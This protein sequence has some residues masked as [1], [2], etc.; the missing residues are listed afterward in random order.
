MKSLLCFLTIGIVAFSA[1]AEPRFWGVASGDMGEN[2]AVLWTRV[3]DQAAPAQLA[4][5]VTV[6]TE[7]S[8]QAA[9]IVLEARTSTAR[10]Y[11]AKVS[12]SGPKPG[13]L[14]YYQ[15][16]AGSLKS[17]VGRFKTG[18]E[19]EALVP[20]TFGFSGDAEGLMR[21]CPLT[22]EFPKLGLDFFA[23]LGEVIYETGSQGSTAG[24]VSGTV[25]TPS[26]K[27]ATRARLFGDYS[28]KYREQPAAV[29][30]GGQKGAA[31]PFRVAGQLHAGQPLFP[32]WVFRGM[33]QT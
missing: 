27:G 3:V 1:S 14:S 17:T 33:V 15:F 32:T 26:D 19:A 11:T 4:L 28:R 8:L 29:N 31:G 16:V 12:A 18:P 6:S 20:V 9:P 30:A 2:D 21:P 7:P 24:A 23:F 25:P 13:K 10:D 22:K 5:T